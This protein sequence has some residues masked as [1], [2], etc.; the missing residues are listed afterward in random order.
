MKVVLGCESYSRSKP[1]PD[2]FLEAARILGLQ[3][4]ECLVFED[5]AAGIASAKSAGMKVVALAAANWF[6]HDHGRADARLEHWNDVT[7]E[8]LK[9]QGLAR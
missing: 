5:S 1:A 6:G 2:G 3:P 9:A 8:W 4:K 7:P